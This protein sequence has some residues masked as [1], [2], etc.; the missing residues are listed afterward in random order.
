VFLVGTAASVHL[1]T[2][3]R[4]VAFRFLVIAG[5]TGAACCF[6]VQAQQ[7]GEDCLLDVCGLSVR[8]GVLLLGI[9][10]N[11]YVDGDFVGKMVPSDALEALFADRPAAL[12][13]Y[14]RFASVKRWR[15]RV[16]V[17]TTVAMGL[18]VYGLYADVPWLGHAQ[19]A[20][21]GLFA[22]GVTLDLVAKSRFM[23]AVTAYNNTRPR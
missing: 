8:G 19:T 20:S 2:R 23:G 21:L 10:P 15:G 12:A 3:S 22:G 1:L 6:E 7:P 17:L 13:D 18:F 4:L 9:A 14:E 5:V 11:V 16:L